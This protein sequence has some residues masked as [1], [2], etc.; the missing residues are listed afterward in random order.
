M[1]TIQKEATYMIAPNIGR[2][3][4][5]DAVQEQ[6]IRYINRYSPCTVADIMYFFKYS[7]TYVNKI[8]EKVIRNDIFSIDEN[9]FI[10]EKIGK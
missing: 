7:K 8:L 10:R 9:G 6:I 2:C 3:G 1:L 4:K 5:E